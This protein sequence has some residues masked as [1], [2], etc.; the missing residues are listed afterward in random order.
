MSLTCRRLRDAIDPVL[1]SMM[2][3]LRI[4]DGDLLSEQLRREELIPRPTLDVKPQPIFDN[5]DA[6][7]FL[8]NLCFCPK[9]AKSVTFAA[10]NSFTPCLWNVCNSEC[11]WDFPK[12]TRELLR[13]AWKSAGLETRPRHAPAGDVLTFTELARTIKIST[14]LLMLCPNIEAIESCEVEWL[15]DIRWTKDPLAVPGRRAFQRL[16]SITFN[17]IVWDANVEAF[18]TLLT[19]PSLERISCLGLRFNGF[20]LSERSC[21]ISGY[22]NPCRHLVVPSIMAPLDFKG[23]D[24]T[25]ETASGRI[26]GRA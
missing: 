5:D 26:P 17:T 22:P 24:V 11:M 19:I 18:K 23:W 10:L 15:G 13:R 8:L 6:I 25:I 4:G 14:L 2:R 21:I 16:R 9:L 20:D 12:Y 1:A 3:V 7:A